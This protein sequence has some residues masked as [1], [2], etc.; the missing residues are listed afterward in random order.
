[1]TPVIFKYC[2]HSPANKLK[3]FELEPQHTT[4]VL[5]THVSTMAKCI[6]GSNRWHSTRSLPFL[7]NKCQAKIHRKFSN[8]ISTINTLNLKMKM[9][10][11]WHTHMTLINPGEVFDS[12]YYY[13]LGIFS[14][15]FIGS[16]LILGLIPVYIATVH[17]IHSKVIYN[18]FSAFMDWRSAWI[19]FQTFEKWLLCNCIPV[20]FV[21]VSKTIVYA[22]ND[23]ALKSV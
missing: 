5:T 18:P 4:H 14:I 6:H 1:M 21:C 12:C 13:S 9:L 22:S 11:L 16:G 17:T 20:T 2:K 7:K 23:T 19:L 10:P 8:I 3:N 15:L